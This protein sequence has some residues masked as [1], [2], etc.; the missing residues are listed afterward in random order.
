METVRKRDVEWLCYFLL[1]NL[2]TEKSISEFSP[3]VNMSIEQI[4]S[5]CN[6]QDLRLDEIER[7]MET[8]T[9]TEQ[10]NDFEGNPLTVI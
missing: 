10:K 6:K 9:S 5:F 1:Q 7:L 2:E 8:N 3:F 4:R